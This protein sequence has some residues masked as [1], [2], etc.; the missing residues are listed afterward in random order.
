MK[1][2]KLST[3]LKMENPFDS[4]LIN[5]FFLKNRSGSEL[6]KNSDSRLLPHLKI[7]SLFSHQND[8]L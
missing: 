4:G 3:D 1:K 7:L 5:F 2:L 6:F 8:T